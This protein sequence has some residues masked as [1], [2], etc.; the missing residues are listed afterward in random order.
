MID[1]V[2]GGA[3]LAALAWSSP[4]DYVGPGV[5]V[6]GNPQTVG[7]SNVRGLVLDL[8]PAERVARWRY[9]AGELPIGDLDAGV[10]RDG[11]APSTKCPD[12]FYRLKEFNGGKDPTAPDCATRWRSS[13]EAMTVNR[14][15]DCIGGAAW[16][17]GFDRYQPVRFA[18]VYGGWIN[19]D[20]MVMDADAGAKCFRRIAA[21]VPGCFIVARSGA[22]GAGTVGHIGG[23]VAVP[24]V[25]LGQRGDYAA[26]GVVD[27]AARNGR[28]N[29]RRD[30]LAWHGRANFILPIMKA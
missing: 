16:G 12:I 29:K 21:P 22:F 6:G 19:C 2:V 20:S 28:A 1:P 17:A 11:L 13:P 27:V 9:L 14:T 8:S 26:L 3:A 7:G 5:T 30:G 15:S 4:D 24:S 25:W 23:V 10:R 18:H